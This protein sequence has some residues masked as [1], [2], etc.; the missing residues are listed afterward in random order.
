MAEGL[1]DFFRGLFS[2]KNEKLTLDKPEE[3]GTYQTRT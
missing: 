1:S 3:L 2:P